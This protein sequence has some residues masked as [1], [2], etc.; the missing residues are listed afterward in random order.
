MCFTATFS[1]LR[2]P[3]S[4]LILHLHKISKVFIKTA[5]KAHLKREYCLYLAS[6]T[7]KYLISEF[8]NQRFLLDNFEISTSY[9][10]MTVIIPSF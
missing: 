3:F 4:H 8:N 1:L 5:L 6:N 2:K 9:F 10:L 7:D